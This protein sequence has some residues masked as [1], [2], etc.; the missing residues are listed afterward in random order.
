MFECG[1]NLTLHRK[2]LVAVE[3]DTEARTLR[4]REAQKL[5]LIAGRNFQI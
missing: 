1:D 4:S 2:L 3:F 5:K